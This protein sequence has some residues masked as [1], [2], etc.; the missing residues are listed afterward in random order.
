MS[1]IKQHSLLRESSDD[2]RLSPEFEAIAAIVEHAV[3]CVDGELNV[4]FFNQAFQD[5][6]N[7]GAD[8]LRSIGTL[9]SILTV[10]GGAP[11]DVD[12]AGAHARREAVLSRVRGG[13][14]GPEKFPLGATRTMTIEC[15]VMSNGA[16]LVVFTE[17]PDLRREEALLQRKLREALGATQKAEARLSYAIEN[18]NQGVVLYDE[19]WRV[20]AYNQKWMSLFGFLPEFIATRPTLEQIIRDE[21]ERGIG[22][23]IVGDM[24]QKVQS[25]LAQVAEATGPYLSEQHLGDGTVIEMWTNPL[26]SG[27][28]VRT[29]TDITPRRRNETELR[30]AKNLAEAATVAKSQFLASMSH[31]LRTPLNAI[32]GL[33]EM[34]R[35]DAESQALE[36][37]VEPLRRVERAGTHLLWLINEILDLSKLEAGKFELQIEALDVAA[38]VDEIATT[39]KPLADE[40]RN[41]V[42]L[43]CDTNPHTIRA[44]VMRLRQ[45]VLNLLSNACKFTRDGEI[46]LRVT[47]QSDANT[48]FT[49][50]SVQDTG[51]GIAS[52]EFPNLFSEFTQVR[53]D[54]HTYGGTGLG[55]AISHRLCRLMGASLEVQSTLGQGSTFSFTLPSPL[56][57][58]TPG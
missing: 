19:E 49:R 17:T 58:R 7:V 4:Y 34:L 14:F 42:L 33:T 54:G 1:D 23:E 24:E 9:S 38:F 2:S 25:W 51:I 8:T 53:Q 56:E 5:L 20:S 11:D 45:V 48:C 32:I 57:K 43:E 6:S 31:E 55:L 26:P 3:L 36:R 27:G 44:D 13:A 50:F 29:F 41:R 15:R 37:F 18:I 52:E 46:T 28:L 40:N 10:L 21:V 16:R 12:S 39:V 30:E 35:E 47:Q 22:A